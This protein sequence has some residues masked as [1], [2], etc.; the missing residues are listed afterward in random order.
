VATTFVTPKTWAVGDVYTSGD[1]NT[2]TRDNTVW[3]G[4]DKPLVR[5]YSSTTQSVL[6]STFTILTF[7]NER[8]DN[9]NLHSSTSSTSKL[10]IPSGMGGTYLFGAVGNWSANP[11]TSNQ[12]RILIGG[13]L[14][15]ALSS[16]AAAGVGTLT[17]SYRLSAGEY[18]E[19]QVFQNS[20]GT[21]NML[22]S[23][24][25]VAYANEFWCMWVGT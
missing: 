11:G 21:I 2:Y 10:I 15:V 9:Q 25:T 13:T 8:F 19:A 3:L 17:S 18:I 24:A 7:E 23:T 16:M 4:T 1:A 14:I 22:P 20:G 12:Q 5:A 6:N